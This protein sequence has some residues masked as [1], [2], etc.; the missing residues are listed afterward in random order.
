MDMVQASGPG[1]VPEASNTTSGATLS[2]PLVTDG[3]KASKAHGFLM[4]LVAL[5]MIPFD[6]I[7]IGLLKWRKLHIFISSLTLFLVLIAMS[8]GIYVSTEYIRVRGPLQ[9][10]AYY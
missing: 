3:D 5:V 8:L 10:S 2:G 1:G 7:I 4:A 6:V 9:I